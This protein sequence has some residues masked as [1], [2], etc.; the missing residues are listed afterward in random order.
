MSKYKQVMT[1]EKTLPLIEQNEFTI[2]PT[3]HSRMRLLELVQSAMNTEEVDSTDA[4]GIKTTTRTKGKN[5]NINTIADVCAEM[6][7]EGCWEHESNGKRIKLKDDE[8]DTTRDYILGVV[9]QSDI[10]KVYLNVL[11]AL[12]ILPKDKLDELMAG[13]VTAEKK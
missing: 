2:Y 13:Q 3:I 12:N 8:K 1:G 7:W 5:F 4:K 10:M 11:G 9:L 6:I